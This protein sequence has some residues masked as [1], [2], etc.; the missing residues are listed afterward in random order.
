G[1]YTVT[2][3]FAEIYRDAAGARLF[4]VTAEG[5]LV[6]DDLDIWSEAGGKDIAY[7]VPLTVT[8]DD[9]TLNLGF[10][11]GV[12]ASKLSAI[13][14]ESA[15]GTG[16]AAPVAVNDTGS[17]DED[18]AVVLSVLANDSDPDGD[19]L[20]IASV[21]QG[22][23]G[24]VVVN[25][26]GTLTY[27][28]DADFHGTDGFTYTVSDGK[29]G[30]DTASVAVTVAP[31]NDAPVAADDTAGTAA[32]TAV[33]VS[34]LANDSDVDGDTLSV[35]SFTQGANG[36]V[37]DN[38]DGTL[39]YA[40]NAG[41]AG[42]DSFSYTATDGQGGTDTATVTVTVA[43]DGGGAPM[44]AINVGGG[45]YAGADGVDYL[46]VQFFS[47]GKT[48]QT[49]SSIAGTTDDVLYQSERYGNF[50][51]AL[52]VADGTYTVTLRFAEIYHKVAGKR[53]FDVTAEGDLV[54]DDLDI[55]S[56]AGGKDIAYDVP[57]TVT[58]D[59]G[60]LN[61]GFITGVDAS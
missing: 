37:T 6:L 27:T 39:T 30:T 28:P 10:I 7:D 50:S 42:T 22:A 15:G 60:T 20:S 25:P 26:D 55:W 58:V 12:D 49:T 2:L 8:V 57:L 45:A 4:D 9:G 51:Y 24:S 54:L 31:V 3:R 33:T 19:P 21:T 16:N 14:V 56:E 38:G 23:N 48:Y 11:T 1:T 35:G 46:A 44:L 5:D 17:L 32:G 36:S 13:L 29:G 40:P 43:A 53:V 18:T 34:V 61:L 41:F 52:P 59:D 47:G